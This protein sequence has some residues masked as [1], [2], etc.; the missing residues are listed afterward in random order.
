MNHDPAN[1]DFD[2]QE[3]FEDLALDSVLHEYGESCAEGA[4]FLSRVELRMDS[5]SFF[6][7]RSLMDQIDKASTAA[8]SKSASTNGSFTNA[9]STFGL[10]ATAESCSAKSETASARS[11]ITSRKLAVLSACAAAVFAAVGLVWMFSDGSDLQFNVAEASLVGAAD[12]SIEPAENI[13]VA[14]EPDAANKDAA[15]K[16]VDSV[17]ANNDLPANDSP[18][19][20]KIVDPIKTGGGDQIASL[21]PVKS[22]Y[23][24]PKPTWDMVVQVE[25]ES[26]NRLVVS[27][28]DKKLQNT[29][30]MES[31]DL[32]MARVSHEVA[33]RV[34][35]LSPV[36]AKH[37]VGRV[38]FIGREFQTEVRFDGLD[39]MYDSINALRSRVAKSAKPLPGKVPTMEKELKR[40][41]STI[42]KRARVDAST[43][44][45]LLSLAAV[46][47]KSDLP[48]IDACVNEAET[49][50]KG[51]LGTELLSDELLF[52]EWGER[53]KSERFQNY[54]T[55]TALELEK[56]ADSGKLPIPAATDAFLPETSIQTLAAAKLKDELADSAVKI[57]IYR[58]RNEFSGAQKLISET[59]LAGGLAFEAEQLLFE[60]EEIRKKINLYQKQKSESNDRATLLRVAAA[61][62][63]L[64]REQE[65]LT[66]ERRKLIAQSRLAAAQVTKLEGRDELDPIEP[67]V[68]LLPNRKDL[69]GLN[70]VMGDECH[71]KE[72]NAR[73][74]QFVSLTTGSILQEFDP[75][76]ARVAS[77]NKKQRMGAVKKM[78]ADIAANPKA[79]QALTTLDQMLQIEGPEIRLELVKALHRTNSK[80]GCGLLTC[81][82]RYDLDPEVRV[83]AVDAL[84]SYPAELYRSNLLDGFQYPWPQVAKHSAEALVRL[85]DTDAVPALVELLRRPDPRIPRRKGEDFVRREL[86]AIN[87]MKNCTLCHADSQNPDDIGR[88]LIPVWGLPLSRQY[89]QPNSG[90]MV[91]ADVT[92]LRQDFS[93]VQP[94]EDARPWP[95]NQR[96]D[97]VVRERVISHQEGMEVAEK[98]TGKPNEYHATIAKALRMLT[99]ET[100]TD[101]SYETWKSIVAKSVAAKK[102]AR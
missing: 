91:R 101:D 89:Y 53:A 51:M 9:S 42:A 27:I 32:V 6:G 5:D 99:K 46:R 71:L 102:A 35:F 100:P 47:S 13:V 36:L 58:N 98:L 41:E 7:R 40:L 3:N 97:Y 64:R 25:N 92:Y 85:N 39:E 19:K 11:A 63:G 61:L 55:V 77:R 16:S 34:H 21:V 54:R 74:L 81:Y 43:A 94:V 44:K 88:G 96:F 14:T 28:N 65:R 78:I 57:G 23:T 67:L 69:Q 62:R 22:A 29:F 56:F 12:S 45:S 17:V 10:K 8:N 18:K 38:E 66:R 37:W 4:E 86:V 30:P 87:H 76:G 95:E 93:V 72:D 1:Q 31:F 48:V 73:T 83:A 70:L 84:R 90:A 80:I 33:R 60:S 15:N 50:L 79:T 68:M 49:V 20:G 82:A 75:F 26:R 2:E 24:G 59:S 52:L